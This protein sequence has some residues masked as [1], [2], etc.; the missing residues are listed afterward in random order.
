[1]G[2]SQSWVSTIAKKCLPPELRN[3]QQWRHDSGTAK[4]TILQLTDQGMTTRQIARKL[5]CPNYYVL[6]TIRQRTAEEHA[7]GRRRCTRCTFFEEEC[8]P[9]GKDGLCH[10]CRVELSGINLLDYH[11]SGAAFEA[12]FAD[13]RRPT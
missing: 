9:I 12:A 2:Y 1:M 4:S 10:L 11:E 6:Q 7:R 8:N 3:R 13:S 5:D